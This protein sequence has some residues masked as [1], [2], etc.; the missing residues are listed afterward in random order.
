VIANLPQMNNEG[1]AYYVL[2]WVKAAWMLKNDLK[3]LK[4]QLNTQHKPTNPMGN[5][6]IA[7]I[8]II[9]IAISRRFY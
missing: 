6:F 5:V 4:Y 9:F 2:P 3:L 1:I 8:A 7:W